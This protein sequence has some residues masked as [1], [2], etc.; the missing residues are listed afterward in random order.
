VI[1]DNDPDSGA[2]EFDVTARLV[3]N[4]IQAKGSPADFVELYILRDST[5]VNLSGY[6]LW[7]DGNKRHVFAATSIQAG[8]ESSCHMHN[9]VVARQCTP[10]GVPPGLGNA[11][12]RVENAAPAAVGLS[13]TY[14]DV[15]VD[16]AV[17]AK[18]GLP[19]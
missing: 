6:S 19:G 4:E 9:H 8:L 18:L 14:V 12:D 13:V 10:S 16:P 5:P 2:T 7:V 3:I 17:I 11:G 15:F 1:R